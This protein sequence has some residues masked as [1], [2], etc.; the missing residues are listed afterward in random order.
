MKKAASIP[1]SAITRRTAARRR[2]ISPALKV[3]VAGAPFSMVTRSSSACAMSSLPFR[4]I[5]PER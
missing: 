4:V 2:S 1:R 3:G 5:R